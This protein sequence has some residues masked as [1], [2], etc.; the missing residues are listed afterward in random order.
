MLQTISIT[1]KGRVQGVYYRQSTRKKAIEFGITGEVKNMPDG[2]VHVIATGS[3]EQLNKLM[4]WCKAGPSDAIVTDLKIE[5]L[6]FLFFTGFI[7][8]R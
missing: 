6:P 8:H 3:T 7:I 2:S 4:L 1:I 5:E